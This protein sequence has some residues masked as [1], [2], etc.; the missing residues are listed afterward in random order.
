MDKKHRKIQNRNFF[1]RKARK[2]ARPIVEKRREKLAREGKVL[3][4]EE[5]NRIIENIAK[6]IKREVAVRSVIAAMGLSAGI[7][8]GVGGT[9]LLN[10]ASNKG[11]T[12]TE[13]TIKIDAVEA[14]KDIVIRNES[15][16]RDV[17]INSVKVDLNKQENEIKANLN[18]EVGQLKTKQDALKYIKDIYAKEYNEEHGTNISSDNISISKD[19]YDITVKND[20]AEN[21]DEIIRSEYDSSD[22]YSKGVY[23]ITVKTNE[24]EKEETIARDFNDNC[25]RVY[26]ADE[27]VEQYKENTASKLG[28]IIIDGTDYAIS[29][30]ENKN[31]DIVSEY[32]QRLVN[33]IADHKEQKIDEIIKGNK[34][35][36]TNNDREI[37]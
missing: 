17:F 15:N 35:I 37:E 5:E 14:D 20:K 29:L 34:E 16:Q 1:I 30:E 3:S 33:S 11:I 31:S 23:T 10:E 7:G 36:N 8:I 13:S 4:R 18:D 9:K 28:N 6:R 2:K 22:S 24:G 25:V 26:D 19:M 12:K 27:K 21:G 32:K